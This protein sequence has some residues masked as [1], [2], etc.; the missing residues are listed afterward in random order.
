M[1]SWISAKSDSD[2]SIHNVP[3]GLISTTKDAKTRPATRI[4]D[5]VVDLSLLAKAGLLDNA[6]L[7]KEAI[8][9]LSEVPTRPS[10]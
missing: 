9:S 3:F 2:F 10:T 5:T 6:G 7:S 8:A 4:G 1:S